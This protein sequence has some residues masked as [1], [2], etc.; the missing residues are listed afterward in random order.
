MSDTTKLPPAASPRRRAPRGPR[1]RNVYWRTHTT[2]KQDLRLVQ[3][4]QRR[5]AL[6]ALALIW[7]LA[8]F[9]LGDYTLS[10]LCLVGI[11]M[12]GAL[13]QNLLIGYA[14]Q[15]SLGMAG[16]LAAGGFTSAILAQEW[17]IV[18][19]LVA[20]PVAAVVGM[21]LGLVVGL[22]SLRVKGLYLAVGTLALFSVIVYA[23]GRYQHDVTAGAGVNLPD[24]V[25]A[26]WE[27]DSQAEWFV[28]ISLLVLVFSLILLNLKR[29]RT[30]RA[31]MAIRDRDVA[32]MALG[33]GLARYKLLAFVISSG[34][35]TSVG[36]LEAYYGHFVSVEKYT[37]FL[38]IQYL[39]MIV[40]GGLGTVLG[41]LIG[42]AVIVLLP[43][44]IDELLAALD[45]GISDSALFPI[46]FGL[47]GVLMA[48][49][50]V[51]E[52]DGVVGVW[53]RVK[54]YFL[55]WPYRAG[56]RRDA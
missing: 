31:W 7:A 32:A 4:P 16:F 42:A 23:A 46:Q 45:V 35:A 55:L 52:P 36:A 28:V 29:S 1:R 37:F 51:I 25:V 43:Y 47:F 30:G 12:M 21:V 50:L 24:P 53:R 11:A 48:V 40:V 20:L 41:S 33:V 44:G 27:L 18:Q 19:P 34:M 6:V 15:I 17:G 2:L 56:S 39:A 5:V 8:L 9:S 38:T 26:G 3:T 22:P 49:F 54:T 14:G 13:S 10:L